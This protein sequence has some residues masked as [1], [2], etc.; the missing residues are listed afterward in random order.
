VDLSGF[1]LADSTNSTPWVIPTGTII[2]PGGFLL[3]WADSETQQNGYGGPDLH[4]DFRLGASGEAIILRAPND[5]IVDMITF[6]PQT[7]NISQGRWPDANSSFYFMTIPTPRSA[8]TIGT[9]G[10]SAPVLSA[11]GNKNVNEGSA[12]VFTA[13]AADPDSGQT[14]TFSLDLGAPTNA[15]INPGSGVFTWTPNENQGPGSY[16][17]TIRV[18]DNGSPSLSDTETITVTVNEVNTAPI[19][20][21][22][23]D[24][25]INEGATVS[26]NAIASDSDVPAQTL[27]FSLDPGAPPG[28]TINPTTGAFNWSPTETQ[29]PGSYPVTIR[30]TDNG[31]PVLN[32]A[33]TFTI[34]VSSVA[35]LR[36]TGITMSGG[37]SVTLTWSSQAGKTYRVESKDD[38]NQ[39]N[40]SPQG[41]YNATDSTTTATLSI[42]GAP[43]RYYRIQQVN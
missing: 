40:W 3:V 31:S 12:L 25:S 24:Q 20:N 22:I 38:L 27:T 42:S 36:L 29:G 5:A 8:N 43:R 23:S 10:N 15:T 33:K 32:D 26:F 2:A 35:E 17:I 1:K 30:V 6:G 34:V 4:S 41:D 13:L 21:A 11:I 28:G 9:G 7:N 39:A 16:P 18:T 19:L 37:A 14:L